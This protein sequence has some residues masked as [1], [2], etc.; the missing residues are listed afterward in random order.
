MEVKP[1]NVVA[2][3]FVT[4]CLVAVVQASRYGHFGEETC[5]PNEFCLGRRYRNI[6]QTCACPEEV[7]EIDGLLVSIP[8][9]CQYDYRKRHFLCRPKVNYEGHHPG[10]FISRLFNDFT[11][12]RR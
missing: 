3:M 7:H 8:T 1:Q 6:V 9:Q 4:V 12:K 11:N 5:Q 10:S 2:V